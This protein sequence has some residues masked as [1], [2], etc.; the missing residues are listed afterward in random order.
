MPHTLLV[1]QSCISFWFQQNV[2]GAV[3]YHVA[4]PSLVRRPAPAQKAQTP[5]PKASACR[6][7]EIKAR[8]SPVP[9]KPRASC[10]CGW[11]PLPPADWRTSGN[12]ALSPTPCYRENVHTVT[13]ITR[14][15][16]RRITTA[17]AYHGR[18]PFVRKLCDMPAISPVM[19]AG[20][21]ATAGATVARLARF[22]LSLF[23]VNKYFRHKS[24]HAVLRSSHNSC[25][26][27]ALHII[28]FCNGRYRSKW[29]ASASTR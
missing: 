10:Y 18:W 20:V 27:A 28:I 25:S 7:P 13:R 15:V 6:P 8:E 29:P 12:N 9:E 5:R 14:A 1:E 23:F 11:C 24:R 4:A 21:A 17:V 16:A 19:V 2:D 3:R 22:T 26:Q